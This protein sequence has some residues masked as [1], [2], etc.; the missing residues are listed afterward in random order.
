MY[1]HM[2]ANFQQ[3]ILDINFCL[4]CPTD[5]K[6]TQQSCIL[7]F[8]SIDTKLVLP[9]AINGPKRW[10]LLIKCNEDDFCASQED[11]AN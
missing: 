4:E 8:L 3:M 6:S 9:L 7:N 11:F 5:L 1:V 10:E 2:W